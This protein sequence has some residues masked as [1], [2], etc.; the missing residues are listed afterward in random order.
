MSIGQEFFPAPNM[1]CQADRHGRR[2]SAIAPPIRQFF[3]TL[4][5]GSMGPNPVVLEQANDHQRIP[6]GLLFCKGMGFSRQA[7]EPIAQHPIQSFFVHTIRT[8]LRFLSQHGMHLNTNDPSIHSFFD[9][10]GKADILARHQGR[11]PPSAGRSGIPIHP[12]NS[13]EIARSS[14]TEPSHASLVTGALACQAHHI[15]CHLVFRRSKGPSHHESTGPFL[16]Q[17]SPPWAHFACLA[18]PCC[19]ICTLFFTKDQKASTSTWLNCSSWTNTSV[20]ASACLDAKRSQRPMLSYLWPVISSAALKLPRRMTISRDRATS[21]TGV[22]KRYIGVPKVAPKDRPHPRHNQ[23][24]RPSLRPLRTVC[25]PPQWGQGGLADD[26]FRAIGQFLS[27]NIIIT[28]WGDYLSF[29]WSGLL[30][31]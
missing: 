29:R 23:R 30:S 24:C 21:A 15:R 12:A 28:R 1:V 20:M 17:T 13:L 22:R 11:T 6:R 19:N 5:Q 18:C 27:P 10:L 4:T 7:V 9:R 3:C 31:G 2:A 8:P 16:A 14:V 25:L 26:A